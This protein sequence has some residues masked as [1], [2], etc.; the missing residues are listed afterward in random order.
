MER[1]ELDEAEV[2]FVKYTRGFIGGV[3]SLSL[4][5]VFFTCLVFPLMLSR[6]DNDLAT[7]GLFFAAF[8]ITLFVPNHILHR[9]LKIGRFENDG[10]KIVRFLVKVAYIFGCVCLAI[11][12]FLAVAFLLMISGVL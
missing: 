7:A 12:L 11:L 4:L 3:I 10:V 1:G 9:T 2:A 8:F 6:L 5:I